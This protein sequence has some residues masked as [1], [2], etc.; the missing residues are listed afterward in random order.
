MR[1]FHA[2]R[3][4]RGAGR[5]DDVGEAGC[6]RVA[7]HGLGS[8]RVA[9]GRLVDHQRVPRATGQARGQPIA[10]N[11][12]RR[13]G[14]L[15]HEGDPL[16]RILTVERHVRG[17][18]VERAERGDDELRGAIE[19]HADQHVAAGA[20]LAQSAREP[21]GLDVER[22]VGQD[23][24]AISDGDVRWSVT[25]SR[26]NRGRDDVV[27]HC[28]PSIGQWWCQRLTRRDRT[29][30][31]CF[32]EVSSTSGHTTRTRV[33]VIDLF[34]GEW[35]TTLGCAVRTGWAAARP[36]APAVACR[37][38]PSERRARPA[39]RHGPRACTSPAC[40]ADRGPRSSS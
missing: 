21:P 19:R 29:L 35:P 8:E 23:V 6:R 38:A 9:A 40:G 1:D 24:P 20:E 36:A 5:I 17:T 16:G 37:R 7:T 28:R 12:D 39:R 30:S 13:R 14:V 31:P 33:Q 26:V 11:D 32:R 10:R 3:P 4:P 27:S 22:L 18:G 34:G 15:E 2:L 25:G